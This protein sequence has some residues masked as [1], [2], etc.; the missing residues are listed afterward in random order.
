[1]TLAGY[2]ALLRA[3]RKAYKILLGNPKG[4]RPLGKTTCR[5]QENIEM[6]LKG[7]GYEDVDSVHSAQ[8]ILRIL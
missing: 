1:M 5:H 3:I 2:V 7:S 6:E 8:T 4:N